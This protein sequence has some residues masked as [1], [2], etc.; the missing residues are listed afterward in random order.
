MNGPYFHGGVDG[1]NPGDLLIPG[2]RKHHDGC[3]WC[4]A[5]A[6]GEAHLGMDGPSQVEGI[7]FTTDRLYAKHYASL[8]GAGDLYRVTPVGDVQRSEEDSYDTWVAPTARVEAVVERAVRLT[9][10]ERRR[11]A[12]EWEAADR[13]KLQELR[14]AR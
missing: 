1:L 11:L 8:Y 3:P 9:H 14:R 5:R 13:R 6:K 12:R 2:Q 4:E 10:K 7:Y